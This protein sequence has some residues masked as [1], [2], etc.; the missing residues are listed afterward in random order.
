[1]RLPFKK[2]VIYYLKVKLNSMYL[3][4]KERSA[5][6]LKCFYEFF[7]FI[8]NVHCI[9]KETRPRVNEFELYIKL[10]LSRRSF[11]VFATKIRVNFNNLRWI[12]RRIFWNC[13]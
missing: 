5:H 11:D 12:T 3:F 4:V 8:V 1:M 6:R 2:N 9:N 13:K 7:L 10:L